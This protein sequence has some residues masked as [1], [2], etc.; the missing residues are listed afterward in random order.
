MYYCEV[1]NVIKNLI[2]IHINILGKYTFTVK[3]ITFKFLR[4]T[5]FASNLYNY[6]IFIISISLSLFTYILMFVEEYCI[7]NWNT[8]S[9]T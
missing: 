9:S 6:T 1:E 8:K 2:Q 7:L 3:Y 5:Y 4:A